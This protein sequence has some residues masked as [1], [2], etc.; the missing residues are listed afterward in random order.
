[1]AI[2][3]SGNKIVAPFSGVITSILEAKNGCAIESDLG[4]EVFVQFGSGFE[5]LDGLS[6]SFAAGS[7]VAGSTPIL[8]EDA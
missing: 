7:V 8:A 3:P 2:E 6:S 4:F 1:V 5:L